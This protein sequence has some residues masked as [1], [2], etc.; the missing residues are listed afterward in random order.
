MRLV[1]LVLLALVSAPGAAQ[2]AEIYAGTI[3]TA[4]VV[5]LLDTPSEGHVGHYF[6]RRSGADIVL[7]GDSI[8]GAAFSLTEV[9]ETRT[10]STPLD[11]PNVRTSGHWRLTR[12]GDGLTGEWRG[13][14]RGA[15]QP[16]RLRLLARTSGHPDGGHWEWEES[17]NGAAELD[18]PDMPY[19]LERARSGPTT[20]GP[21]LRLGAGAY[22]M[23]TDARTGVSTPR[24][25]RFPDAAQMQRLNSVF[26]ADRALEIGQT[27]TCAAAIIHTGVRPEAGSVTHPR[28][29]AVSV[30]I[31]H[32]GARLVSF[33]EEGAVDCGGEHT[34][35]IFQSRTYDARTGARFDP[36]SL[37]NFSPPGRAAAFWRLWS[38]RAAQHVPGHPYGAPDFCSYLSA[39]NAEH[40]DVAYR[41]TDRGL[42]VSGDDGNIVSGPVCS[43]DLVEIPLSDL[44][45]FLA[46]GAEAYWR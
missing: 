3:G 16:V 38:E 37:L 39:E 24:L 32:L 20:L 7:N 9:V 14:A 2:G 25:T 34:N 8:A 28:P 6:Y 26:E 33:T 21:E 41:L 36:A 30:R 44:R 22:R 42:M 12:A 45:P 40:P 18:Y 4:E 23:V 29:G 17:F 35:Y 11:E 5:V 15:A 19:L 46:P 1:T 27:L 31:H 10:A 13:A 43:I